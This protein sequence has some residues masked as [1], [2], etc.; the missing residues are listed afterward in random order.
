MLKLKLRKQ[1]FF[2]LA[3]AEKLERDFKIKPKYPF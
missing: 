3:I 2:R 1:E